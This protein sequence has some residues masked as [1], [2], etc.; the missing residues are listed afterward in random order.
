MYVLKYFIKLFS[1]LANFI[2]NFKYFYCFQSPP[3]ITVTAV[4]TTATLTNNNHQP[5]P[6]P[7][8]SIKKYDLSGPFIKKDRRQISSRFNA[9]KLNCEIE[10]LPSLKGEFLVKFIL[11][12]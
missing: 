10:S 5:T 12:K 1:C 8:T 11:K 2:I 3:N 6:P 4:S 7:P 9:N